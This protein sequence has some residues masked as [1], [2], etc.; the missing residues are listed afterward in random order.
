MPPSCTPTTGTLTSDVLHCANP[1]CPP[2]HVRS[3]LTYFFVAGS[4]CVL[5]LSLLCCSCCFCC[6]LFVCLLFFA[7][8]LFLQTEALCGRFTALDYEATTSYT[9]SIEA[10]DSLPTTLTST[11]TLTVLVQPVNEFAPVFAPA[12]YTAVLAEDVAAGTR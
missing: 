1:S 6:F 10:V 11:V 5:F 2:S 9:L 4:R 12:T 8:F 3:P 7:L